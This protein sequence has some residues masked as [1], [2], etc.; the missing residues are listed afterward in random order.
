MLPIESIVQ[1]SVDP[2]HSDAEGDE[3]GSTVEEGTT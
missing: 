1:A 2:Q 3:E